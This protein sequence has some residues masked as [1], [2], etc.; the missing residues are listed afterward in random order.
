MDKTTIGSITDGP[1]VHEGR[2]DSGIVDAP[3]V[4]SKP[5][6]T[7]NGFDSFD[8]RSVDPGITPDS[9]TGKRRRGRTPG[10]KNRT[11]SQAKNSNLDGI[12]KTLHSCHMMLATMIQCPECKIS[13]SESKDIADSL[14]AVAEFYD[15][16]GIAPKTMAWVNFAFCLGAVYAPRLNDVHTRLTK[17]R[18]AKVLEFPFVGDN[19]PRE[20]QA[21]SPKVN[22]MPAPPVTDQST[23]GLTPSQLW[24][25]GVSEEVEEI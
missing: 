13:E 1:S 4:T 24:P 5:S 25:A 17:N 3:S 6:D 9:G 23:Q 10:S 18:K 20:S 21:Q 11:G 22:G 12:E 8:P 14:R 19:Q 15:P 2:T 16:M 7:I